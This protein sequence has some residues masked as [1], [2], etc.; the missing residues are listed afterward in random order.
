MAL[1][2][3]ETGGAT[4]DG[5][6]VSAPEALN[7]HEPAVESG[8]RAGS[9]GQCARGVRVLAPWGVAPRLPR[10][11]FGLRSG[12]AWSL[13]LRASLRHTQRH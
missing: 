10:R 3:A 12:K 8:R 5:A 2:E 13:A 7:P 1:W 6:V 4:A 11:M 9:N